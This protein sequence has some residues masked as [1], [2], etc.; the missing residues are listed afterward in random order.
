[1]GITSKRGII[2]DWWR[3]CQ[4]W[5]NMDATMTVDWY[6]SGKLEYTVIVDW[7]RSCQYWRNM[8]ATMAVDWYFFGKLE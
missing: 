7:W 1:M 3:S 4:Y 8:D 5:R 6:F 2:V